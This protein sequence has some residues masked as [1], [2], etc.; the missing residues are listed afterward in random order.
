M[1]KYFLAACVAALCA[2]DCSFAMQQENASYQESNLRQ[3]VSKELDQMAIYLPK[4]ENDKYLV[5]QQAFCNM[6][7]FAK[8]NGLPAL[9]KQ[10]DKFLN[11]MQTKYGS[12]WTI[13]SY[14][15]TPV[16]KFCDI[17]IKNKK[18]LE[19]F[20]DREI[21]QFLK[22]FSITVDKTNEDKVQKLKRV[23]AD[24]AY[25]NGRNKLTDRI[26]RIQDANLKRIKQKQDA[27]LKSSEIE[28]LTDM[29]QRELNY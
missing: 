13:Y 2:A 21:N 17:L 8:V 22:Y 11:R 5:R 24:F 20:A 19:I 15:N 23:A 12:E 16:R 14:T 4:D 27:T 1:Y 7:E 9:Q 6:L 28:E 25:K 3:G 26:K 18:M 29:L 10:V